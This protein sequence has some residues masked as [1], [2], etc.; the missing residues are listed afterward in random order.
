MHH[1]ITTTTDNTKYKAAD[2]I[3]N[4]LKLICSFCLFTI[5]AAIANITRVKGK[6]AI[7]LDHTGPASSD[8]IIIITVTAKEIP[9]PINAVFT[10]SNVSAL[11]GMFF[12][13]KKKNRISSR[14]WYWKD[15]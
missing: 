6:P 1:Q 8:T 5:V 7:E 11:E 9:P 4:L 15:C 12:I 3:K 2:N 10:D 13:I 14:C